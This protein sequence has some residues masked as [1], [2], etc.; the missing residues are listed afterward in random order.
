MIA[1]EVA[2]GLADI[3]LDTACVVSVIRVFSVREDERR[4]RKVAEAVRQRVLEKRAWRHHFDQRF[5]SIRAEALCAMHNRDVDLR[6]RSKD[7]GDVVNQLNTALWLCGPEDDG[8]GQWLNLGLLV[9]GVVLNEVSELQQTHTALRLAQLASGHR[10][11]VAGLSWLRPCSSIPRHRDFNRSG[12]IPHHFG[13][14]V[15]PKK[16]HLRL[17][18]ERGELQRQLEH[19]EREWLAFD[20]S[21]L[22][23]AHNN[24]VDEDRVVLYFVL[25]D[26]Y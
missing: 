8:S 6:R 17:F 12:M 13:L 20:D 10:I 26:E 7:V 5:E 1:I 25:N 19:R 16:C 18:G 14:I 22:H 24:S 15:P 23:S 21:G 9:N 3:N 11:A 2:I 4:A